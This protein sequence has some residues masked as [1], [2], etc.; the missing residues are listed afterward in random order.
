M[1]TADNEQANQMVQHANMVI[2]YPTCQHGCVRGV[3]SFSEHNM[4]EKPHLQA[5]V[6]TWDYMHCKSPQ[7]ASTMSLSEEGGQFHWRL[8]VII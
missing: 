3:S 5:M 7:A 6:K 8:Q 4:G 2:D 1:R